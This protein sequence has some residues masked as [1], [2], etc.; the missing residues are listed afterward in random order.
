MVD[1]FSH[2]YYRGKVRAG[3]S[4]FN[5][6]IE[7]GE[8]RIRLPFLVDLNLLA[9]FLS[10]S[11]YFTSA[12]DGEDMERTGSLG[13]GVFEDREDYYPYWVYQDSLQPGTSIF[14]YPPEDY[15]L[16]GDLGEP[17]HIPMF[18]PESLEELEHWLSV[19][20]EHRFKH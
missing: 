6:R 19:I 11:G 4:D 3:G 10:N 16:A 2:P 12:T 14:A 1:D 15:A 20:W 17:T 5:Y 18:G 13:W 7:D 8:I 9:E